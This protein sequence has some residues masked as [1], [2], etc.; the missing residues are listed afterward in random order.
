MVGLLNAVLLAPK[1]RGIDSVGVLYI[2]QSFWASPCR[3]GIY[4]EVS[5]CR[6]GILL[7]VDVFRPGTCHMSLERS[8]ATCCSFLWFGCVVGALAFSTQVSSFC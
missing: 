4:R 3:R 1:K 7:L 8:A 6:D 5:F 2:L